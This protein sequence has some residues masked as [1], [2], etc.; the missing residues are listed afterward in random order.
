M[1]Q[2]SP[3]VNTENPEDI[4]ANSNQVSYDSYRKV[5]GEKKA[6][7]SKYNEMQ[8]RLEQLEAE[9]LDKEQDAEKRAND[10]KAKFEQTSSDLN[11]LKKQT[12]FNAIKSQ[13]TSKASSEGCVNPEK[14][15]RLLDSNDLKNLEVDDSYRIAEQDL[16]SLIDKAKTEHADIGLFKKADVQVHNVMGQPKVGNKSLDEMTKD[17]LIAYARTTF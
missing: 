6:M 16:T 12:V 15:F 17:E 3:V 5:L 4:S 9:R 13:V 8:A 10:W 1:E 14:L 11:N 7:Q 2:T